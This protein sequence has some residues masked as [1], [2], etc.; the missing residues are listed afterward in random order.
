M[1]DEKISII[2]PVYNTSKYIKDCINSMTSQTYDNLEIVIVNDGSTDNSAEIISQFASKD[3]RIKVVYQENQGLSGARN[4]GIDASS[5]NYIMFLDSDDWIDLKTC[6]TALKEIK[7][8][9]SDVLLWSYVREYSSASKPVLLF[10]DEIKVW[11]EKNIKSLYRQF[12]GLTNEQLSAPQKTDSIVTAW[13]KLYKREAIGVNRFV[14]TKIIGTEDA[15][16]NIQVFSKV[17]RAVYIPNA[18]SHYRKDNEDSLTHKYKK[19]LVYQWKELYSMIEAQLIEEKASQEF[20]AALN[21]RISLSLIGLGLN[22]IG[23]RSLGMS[24]KLDE[25]K[26]I[27]YMPH[28]EKAISVLKTEYLPIHW[29]LF[30]GCAKRKYTFGLLAL[31]YAMNF[32][33]NKV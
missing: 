21:N 24:Y 26:K 28:Y 30:F 2:V 23:D 5:G 16:F 17:K 32:L 7:A 11:D 33:R 22:V 20:F 10:D 31:L 12:V 1:T 29:K 15:L 13:G 4:T 6:E 19:N 3:S 27:L 25:L 9:N 14:D 8:S 18:F